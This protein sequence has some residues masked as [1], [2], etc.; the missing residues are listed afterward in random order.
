MIRKETLRMPLCLQH[1]GQR[2]E[3]A[4]VPWGGALT[5]AVSAGEAETGPTGLFAYL[6]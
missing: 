4:E 2:T 5:A 1:R 3:G 6:V